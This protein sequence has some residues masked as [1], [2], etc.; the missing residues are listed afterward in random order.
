MKQREDESIYVD[1]DDMP[2]SYELDYS[3]AK[4]N[5]FAP[6]LPE[7]SVMV[8]LEPDVAAVF[9]SSEAV[10]RALRALLAVMETV[11]KKN[12]SERSAK[13]TSL[14]PEPVGV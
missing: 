3:K 2:D 4:P 12:I 10:N 5:R 14:L 6:L 9:S 7:D 11:E 13:K 8:V 1:S